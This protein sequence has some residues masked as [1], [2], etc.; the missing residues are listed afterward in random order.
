LE[1]LKM[2]CE[3]RLCDHVCR[4]NVAT[5]MALAEQHGCAALKKACFRFLTSPGNL[6]AVVASD[7]FEH[8]KSSCPSVLEELVAKLAP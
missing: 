2:I 6:K 3:G 4:G 5:T 8:L 7:G 1:R